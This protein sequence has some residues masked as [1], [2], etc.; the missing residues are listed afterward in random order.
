MVSGLVSCAL[1]SSLVLTFVFRSFSI[2]NTSLGNGIPLSFGHSW[3]RCLVFSSICSKVTVM[4]LHQ[5]SEVVVGGL[6]GFSGEEGSS[7]L[8]GVGRLADQL[9]VVVGWCE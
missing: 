6:S 4:G 9:I 1:S 8:I 2:L 7:G 3:S 5:C